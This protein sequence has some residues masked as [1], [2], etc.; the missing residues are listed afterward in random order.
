MPVLRMS[1]IPC[2]YPE[3]RYIVTSGSLQNKASGLNLVVAAIVLWNTVYLE[4]AVAALERQRN[5]GARRLP[6]S[7]VAAWLGTH[8]SDRRLHL[9]S[10][11]NHDVA[12]P[13]VAPAEHP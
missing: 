10:A 11:A 1:A 8:Q 7:P 6:S 5:A 13:A 9:G 4:Q 2:A 3:Q 12:A